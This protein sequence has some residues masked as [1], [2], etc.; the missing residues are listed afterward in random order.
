MGIINKI[1]TRINK[2]WQPKTHQGSLSRYYDFEQVNM[3]SGEWLVLARTKYMLDQ[4][5]PDLYLN[6]Y[7]Y[8]NKFRKIREQNLHLAALDWENLKKRSTNNLR[9]DR[10][11]IQ[12]HE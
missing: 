9:S 10:K 8:Q 7:Y 3:S 1:K 6:G 2:T 4:L 11:N 5:E 12:L